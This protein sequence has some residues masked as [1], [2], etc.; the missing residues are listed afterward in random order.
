MSVVRKISSGTTQTN[1]GVISTNREV[2]GRL[3]DDGQYGYV[4]ILAVYLIFI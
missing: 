2:Q 4:I 3:Q 1:H